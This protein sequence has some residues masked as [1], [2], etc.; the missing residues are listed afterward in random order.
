[1]R[2]CRGSNN[3]RIDMRLQGG[4]KTALYVVRRV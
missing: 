1:M 2:P 4:L 3:K